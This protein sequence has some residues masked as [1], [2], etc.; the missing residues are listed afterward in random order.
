MIVVFLPMGSYPSCVHATLASLGW[1]ASRQNRSQSPLL[2][3]SNLPMFS[4]V[5][6]VSLSVLKK[7]GTGPLLASEKPVASLTS[8]VRHTREKEEHNIKLHKNIMVTRQVSPI[9]NWIISWFPYCS[10]LQH[11]DC[12]CTCLYHL[13]ECSFRADPLFRCSS[14]HWRQWA[15]QQHHH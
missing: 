3:Y 12:E 2:Q 4:T 13:I 9:S 6:M 14:S 11:H 7:L 5:P 15:C 10:E 8:P 1:N